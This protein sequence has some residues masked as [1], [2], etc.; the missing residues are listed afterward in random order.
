MN[1][2]FHLLYHIGYNDDTNLCTLNNAYFVHIAQY[3]DSPYYVNFFF[4][5][6]RIAFEVLQTEDE[7]SAYLIDKQS[8]CA[9]NII[10]YMD[11]CA[12]SD[13]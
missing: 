13:R 8:Y 4:G 1:R 12:I 9:L 6:T 2:D 5:N 7:L 11:F 3:K 10:W